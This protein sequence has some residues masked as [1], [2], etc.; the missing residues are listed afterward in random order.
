MVELLSGVLGAAT[1]HIQLETLRKVSNIQFGAWQNHLYQWCAHTILIY[2]T[3]VF[4]PVKRA[5]NDWWQLFLRVFMFLAYLLYKLWICA[6]QVLCC[7]LPKV[8]WSRVVLLLT[9]LTLCQVCYMALVSTFRMP[10]NMCK[11]LWVVETN[12]MS[13]A[14]EHTCS[15]EQRYDLFLLFSAII[16]LCSNLPVT[17]HVFCC[18]LPKY[19]SCVP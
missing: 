10:Y 7:V 9:V 18:T 17:L 19:S 13:E 12:K 6:T 16:V 4:S 2:D 14:T 11:S 8:Y 1:L 3:L 15:W 5:Q